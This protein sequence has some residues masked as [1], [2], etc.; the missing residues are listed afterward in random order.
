MY[1]Q[2]KLVL[3]QPDTLPFRNTSIVFISMKH[4]RCWCSFVARLTRFL[5][6][7][8]QESLIR[9]ADTRAWSFL[10]FSKA[11]QMIGW[12]CPT[13]KIPSLTLLSMVAWWAFHKC[14]GNGRN[15]SHAYWRNYSIR[16]SWWLDATMS[17]EHIGA[18][19]LVPTFTAYSCTVWAFLSV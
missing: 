1:I 14:G 8:P 4:K 12:S 9:T 11:F 17:A 16:K 18:T 6:S 10:L 3:L 19:D 7:S 2:I 15:I 5:G 13:R